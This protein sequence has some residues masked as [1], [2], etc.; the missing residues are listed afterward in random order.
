MKGFFLFGIIGFFKIVFIL[1]FWDWLNLRGMGML[2]GGRWG[3]GRNWLDNINYVMV[4]VGVI[5]FFMVVWKVVKFFSVWVFKSM[6]D[7]VLDVGDDD[8][9]D[10]VVEIRKDWWSDV[11]VILIFSCFLKFFCLLWS[12]MFCIFLSCFW[13]CFFVLS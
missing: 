9:V 8:E 6:S 4:I 13:I 3:G 1:I 7:C 12:D 5:I 2:W 10:D 11:N